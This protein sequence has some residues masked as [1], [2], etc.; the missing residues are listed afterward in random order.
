MQNQK[1]QKKEPYETFTK[2]SNGAY[3]EK[4]KRNRR[5]FIKTEENRNS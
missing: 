5:L 3:Y 1:P 4:N 2:R